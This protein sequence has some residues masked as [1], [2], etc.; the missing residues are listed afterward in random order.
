MGVLNICAM[1][2]WCVSLLLWFAEEDHS[3][4]GLCDS[5][6]YPSQIVSV[7]FPVISS[8]I[9]CR[10]SVVLWDGREHISLHL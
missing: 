4:L 7:I 9:D 2:L 5:G 3:L 8:F 1:L 10:P 6:G